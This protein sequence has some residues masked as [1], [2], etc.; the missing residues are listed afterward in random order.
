MGLIPMTNLQDSL[1]ELEHIQKLLAG[2]VSRT[3]RFGSVEPLTSH[4][5]D[6]VLRFRLSVVKEPPSQHVSVPT[7]TPRA[8]HQRGSTSE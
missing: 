7:A 2:C 4:R 5:G 6:G 1:A 3:D 8:V